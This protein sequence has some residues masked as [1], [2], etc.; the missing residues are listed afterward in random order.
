MTNRVVEV[1]ALLGLKIDTEYHMFEILPNQY[2]RK[3]PGNFIINALGEILVRKPS[4]GTFSP[5]K[6][7]IAHIIRGK[8]RLEL[9]PFEPKYFDY[10]YTYGNTILGYAVIRVQHKNNPLDLILTAVGLCFKTEQE[11]E[12]NK[13]RYAKMFDAIRNGAKFVLEKEGRE[14]D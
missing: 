6:F 11:A 1:L 2:S 9:V 10:Y 12:A 5:T 3:I 8:L 13:E 4:E 14:N 7:T